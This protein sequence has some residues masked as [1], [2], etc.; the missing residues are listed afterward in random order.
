MEDGIRSAVV[1]SA[2]CRCVRRIVMANIVIGM[3]DILWYSFDVGCILSILR[4][5]LP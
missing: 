1:T 3:H 5:Y 4:K 2:I